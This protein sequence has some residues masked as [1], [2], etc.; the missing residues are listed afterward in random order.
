MKRVLALVAF[1]MFCV[2]GFAQGLGNY[3]FSYA[4]GTYTPIS[5]GIALGNESTASQRFLDPAVP[6]GTT[7]TSSGVGYDLGFGFY[8][9]GQEYDRVG[10]CADGWISLG[11]SWQPTPVNMYSSS[12]T[13]PLGSTVA[14]NPGWQVARIAGMAVDIS[15][16][17][18]A[19][20]R[21]NT[22]GSYPY[23]VFVAQ[24]TNY[25]KAS[26]GTGDSFSFQ[27]RL[28]ETTNKVVLSYGTVTCNATS[29]TIQAGLRGEPATA[30]TNFASRA[31]TTD[32]S[33]TTAGG[34]ATATCTLSSTIY[35]ASGATFTWTPPAPL[36]GTYSIGSG[37]DFTTFAA[38]ISYLN[39]NYPLQGIPQG[40]TIFNVAAGETFT[41]TELLPAITATGSEH[42]P[43][44][45]RKYGTGAN[46]I[47]QVQGTTA[48]SDA[49]IKLEGGDYFTFEGIDIQNYPALS[50]LEYGYYLYATSYNP[51]LHNTI[52]AGGITL[53]RANTST[54]AIYSL[55]GS[56]AGN[57]YNTFS[58]MDIS[59]SNTGVYCY[60]NITV[61]YHNA[62]ETVTDCQ[63]SDISA[64]GIYFGYS[65]DATATTNEIAMCAG[66][67]VEFAGIKT[68][69]NTATGSIVYNTII[70]NTSSAGCY[71]LY[72]YSGAF[73]WGYNTVRDF[74]FSGTGIRYGINVYNLN[75]Q[76]Y[77]N[78]IYNI[79][80]T[81]TLYGIFLN[82]NADAVNVYN[83]EI[84]NLKY[85]G[86]TSSGYFVSGI[87]A[88]GTTVTV[89]NNMIYDLGSTG[90]IAPMIR[91]ITIA[92]GGTI[93]VYYN[94]VFL[95]GGGT[96]TNFGS[97]ALYLSSSSVTLDIR[98]NICVDLSTPG[99]ATSGRAAAIWKSYSG[100]SNIASSSDRNIYYAGTP[101][102]KNL[103]CYDNGVAY[104]TLGDY[105]SA[106]GIFDLGS[107]TENVPFESV[108]EPYDIHITTGAAT[109]AE[110]NALPITGWS[111]DFD[112][113]SRH[114][115]T[116]DIGADEGSFTV[117]AVVPDPAV[118]ISPEDDAIVVQPS[119]TLNWSP[120]VTGGAPTGYLLYLGTNDPPSNIADGIDLLNVTTWDPS[121]D[122]AFLTDYYWKIVPYNATGSANPSLCPVWH[123]QT[124]A[125]PL[126]GEYVIGST[127]DYPSF[128]LAITHLNAAGVG[129]GGVTFKAIAGEVFAENPPAITATGTVGNPILFTSTNPAGTN[130][131]ITPTGGAGSYAIRM[132]GG[133]YITFDH[134]DVANV[135]GATNLEY[136]YWIANTTADPASH[137]SI[138]NC[139]IILDRTLAGS[140]AIYVS[141]PGATT[142][143]SFTGNAID[144]CKN[145]IYHYPETS[146]SGLLISGNTL[147]NVTN[148]AIYCRNADGAQVHTNAISFP[149][150]T[151]DALMGI[152]TYSTTDGEVWNNTITGGS[153]TN[154]CIG[155]SQ[156]AGSVEWHHNTVSNL[157]SG[158]SM[159]GFDCYSGTITLR[160]NHIHS[161]SSGKSIY[162]LELNMDS[163]GTVTAYNNRVHNLACTSTSGYYATGIYIGYSNS[164][165]T[166][167]N[168]I[169]D[170]RNQ[171]GTLAPQV[172]GI[173]V[174]NSTANLYYNT[175]FLDA[176][177][178]NNNY[179]T[180]ALQISGGTSIR[181]NNNIFMN[182]G[183]PGTSGVTA[184]LWKTA[185]GFANIN[186]DSDNNIWY[187]G[188]PGARNLICR[189]PSVYYEGIDAFKAAAISFDQNS[190]TEAVP[191]ADATGPDY[192]LHI[193]VGA[194][195]LAE[196][197]AAPIAGITDDIDADLR[198]ATTP[199]IGA[200]EGNFTV[201]AS[202]PAPAVIVAP[203]MNDYAISIVPTLVWYA[204]GAG[205]APTGYRVW[206]GSNNPP[207]DIAAGVDIGNY[208][209]YTSPVTL[210]YL[211]TYY[212]KI[213]P[214]N[215][216]GSTDPDDCPVW[217]FSTHQVPLTGN[218][219]IGSTG[220][221][222]D[223]T[224]AIKYLNASGTGAGGV[225]FTAVAGEV[226]VENPPA[227]TVTGT[228]ASP[229]VFASTDTLATNPRITPSGGAGTFGIKL[230]GGDYFTFDHIDIANAGGQTTL[231][232]G[233]WL[234]GQAGDGC[235]DVTIKGC[236]ITLDRTTDGAGIRG[237]SASGGVNHRISLL[238]NTITNARAGIYLYDTTAAQNNVLQGNQISSVSEYGIY[239]RY[240]SNIG[241]S[242]NN[243]QMAASNNA[244]FM[245][246][247]G[248]NE[249]GTGQIHHNNITG[250]FTSGSFNGIY[251]H[252]D[253]YNIYANQISGV[254]SSTS[255]YG[256]RNYYGGSNC[257][258]HS[259]QISNLAS[260]GSSEVFAIYM[261]A[262]QVYQNTISGI[263][264]NGPVRGISLATGNVY[265][266]S[267]S[268]LQ[269]SST[270]HVVYGIV[271]TGTVSIHNNMVSDLRAPSSTTMP[272][273]R[274]IQV[275]SGTVNLYY[276]SVLL[277]SS[278]VASHSS[279]ALYLH[280]PTTVLMQNNIFS[281]LS[282]PGASGKAA[283][284]WI[285]E[286]DFAAIAAASNNN[287]WYAGTPS[288]SH[289]VCYYGTNSCQTLEDY[290]AANVGK[291]QNSISEDAPFLGKTAPFDL[292]LDD[293]V[294]TYAEGNAVVVAEVGIDFDGETR[295]TS[296]PDIGADE[297]EF[298]EVQLPPAIPVYLSPLNGATDLALNTPISWAAGPGGGNP[299]YYIVYFG[300][301]STP[302]MVA[303]NVTST[304]YSPSLLPDRT[305]YWKVDA[306]NN[307]GTAAGVAV[308]T[309]DTRA[310]DT[311][312]EFP[313]TE[314]FESGNTNGSTTINRWSRALGSGSYY[315]TANTA[316]NYNR[317]PRTGTFNITL[318]DGGDAWI[319]RP[320]Y[321]T[322]GRSYELELWARQY[323]SSGA[324]AYLQVRYGPSATI[325]GMNQTIINIQEFVNGDYQRASGTFTAPSTGIWYL[326]IHGVCTNYINYISLD[327]ITVNYY[328]PHPVF[329][330]APTA[331]N[332][333]MVN[334]SQSSDAK[335]FVISNTGDADL[336]IS[337]TDIWVEGTHADDFA[338]TDP[339]SD[340]VITPGQS[341]TIYVTFAPL[342]TGA[343]AA[344]LMI[345]DNTQTR[346][347]HSIPLSGRGIGPLVPPCV[348]NFEDGW[349]DWVNVS[350]G[351]TN[352][353]ELGTAISYR[354]SY[355]AYISP[356]SGA[357]HSYNPNSGSWSHFYHDV[358]FPADMTGMKLK[359][360]Y[361]CAGEPGFDYFT[362][363]ITDTSF[364]PVAG[365][366]FSDGMIG[367]P[368][369]SA[370]GWQ[371]AEIA[372]DPSLAGLT[373]R[374]IFS[375]R[376]DSG[377][378]TQPPA[379]IDNLRIYSVWPY[380]DPM[381]APQ[382]PAITAS[383]SNVILTWDKLDGAND[384]IVEDA[385]SLDGPFTPIGRGYNSF[386]TPGSFLQRFFRVRAT[387]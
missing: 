131:R 384:Y 256:I 340:L 380:L 33:A 347:T 97:A 232:Y 54:K 140:T 67:N 93:K 267:I 5:S 62:S 106:T 260:T 255:I 203:A 130:P 274:G 182:T 88:S 159:E 254:N 82:G 120:A 350:T 133:D 263:S 162:G 286:P 168:M 51:C 137:I 121:P 319:F 219:V 17:A 22:I 240:T 35:P 339:G 102:A 148:N 178:T 210:N 23:R 4:V 20:L 372:L 2:F 379:A 361:L 98:N 119:A 73:G 101:G 142:G 359:F 269:T 158:D 383:G 42:H 114:P 327:D 194:S 282:T 111:D 81:G 264:S 358:R 223:F 318:R 89:A 206:F 190:L 192:D 334:V 332:Y 3:T 279:A 312:M 146:S 166:Y 108:A 211:S 268:G 128:T 63:M 222:P 12:Y 65:V 296:S 64:L 29:T 299:D 49:A 369:H 214:Y 164:N 160:D 127:G 330:I 365:T 75:H 13:A 371:L 112:G 297:G 245:G 337:Q 116:P 207:S 150:T 132:A 19:G 107:F 136:G 257:L 308:W 149:S 331:W 236:G 363:H 183:T 333:G 115:S 250:G 215:D 367:A 202:V 377:G 355:A 147:T 197:N 356:N 258:V 230:E 283:A 357:T 163:G 342:E 30:A 234:E 213:V 14:I 366:P 243:I 364:T 186:P 179:S 338:L 6:L 253:K 302:P 110:S 71:A 381:D 77:H 226:F 385:D 95:K 324:Q 204:S 216:N 41:N 153:T 270:Y 218:W 31:T 346:D 176:A 187:A 1:A 200:D 185:D 326:G 360:Q 289:L 229:I 28:E 298:T 145:G 72:A 15:A 46:P 278:G 376:N 138:Q 169:W 310:D 181:S 373:K 86:P 329:S 212:W 157:Q 277:T 335:A 311:I 58:Y 341:H 301:S 9:G 244:A 50:S 224:H 249:S 295:S 70:G 343:R 44:T 59:D 217:Q 151:G 336:L 124:H 69:T 43:I 266:N 228:S 196:S 47:L 209:S 191:I 306:V 104:Q 87:L 231:V 78:H 292:H 129:A 307:L 8:Y 18:G 247:Y 32:W 66:N 323:T 126:T 27:I 188:T 165:T 271:T 304:S 300:E 184:A 167:N 21:I 175:V 25:K 10:I 36:A 281:N 45:F 315:W 85:T 325:A 57:S 305:Y 353:W 246:I 135:S 198:N 125:A 205:G 259:N 156:R 189:T 313:T 272:Q 265:R 173:W 154:T 109:L 100:F 316:T 344:N 105:K 237:D 288:A 52:T 273:L 370:S 76:V 80:S 261:N 83:N 92:S 241:V 37:G 118:V 177:G 199:D 38:A 174:T 96:N 94:S 287:I 262:V 7:T 285:V 113:Q 374:L 251:H 122:L 152:Y 320:I 40:G 303:N 123:F 242:Y 170:I 172:N 368:F 235:T 378:G 139:G 48:T 220:F 233:Y 68:E 328:E 294:Q 362:V 74:T 16:Q 352:K 314:S 56:N 34:A 348:E 276:N 143:Y 117:P 195:T 252:Y 291:D 193:P 248:Y 345:V 309:F 161:L 321:L 382:N 144:N 134:T 317:A 55:G 225:T 349:V 227:I 180:A 354:D 201:P 290:K 221:Y 239:T 61:A 141:G 39:T 375:W 91:G 26:N 90:D 84:H 79:N 24:W 60:G 155:L 293:S 11:Q 284:L 238:R 351:Q 208:L 387:D 103:I 386:G 171:S 99:T 322:A 275:T 53:S 280:D